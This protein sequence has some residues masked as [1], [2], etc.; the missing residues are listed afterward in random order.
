V[1]RVRL[2]GQQQRQQQQQQQQQQQRLTAEDMVGWSRVS[3]VSGACA[4]AT[5]GVAGCVVATGCA[6]RVAH[7]QV[8]LPSR[9]HLAGVHLQVQQL[10]STVAPAAGA[11]EQQ[12]HTSGCRGEA[13]GNG[14]ACSSDASSAG[15][16]PVAAADGAPNATALPADGDVVQVAPEDVDAWARV[17]QR[18]QA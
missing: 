7:V 3:R 4:G 11:S 12:Q 5:A 6:A 2:D 13:G 18:T 9:C 16:A 8:H 10:L 17:Q 14:G 15:T 1:K